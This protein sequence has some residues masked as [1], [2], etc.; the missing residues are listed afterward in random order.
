MLEF[1]TETAKL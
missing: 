1:T